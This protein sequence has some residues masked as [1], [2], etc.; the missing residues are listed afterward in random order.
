MGQVLSPLPELAY[1]R[2]ADVLTAV[3][4]VIAVGCA[5]TAPPPAPRSDCA[6][7]GPSGVDTARAW[8]GYV[9]AH[10]G[11]VALAVDD[12]RGARVVLRPDEEQPLGSAAQVVHL[13]AYGGPWPRGG[14]VPMTRFG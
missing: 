6:A 5:S 9:A 8:T 10:R 14:C 4:V 11:D 7:P 3:L 12:G 2:I 13:A 1:L